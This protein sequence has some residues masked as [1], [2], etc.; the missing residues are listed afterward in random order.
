ML[1]LEAIVRPLD[2]IAVYRRD[3]KELDE[4]EGRLI[5]FGGQ[6]M[7]SLAACMLQKKSVSCGSLQERR[8]SVLRIYPARNG[9]LQRSMVME[10]ATVFLVVH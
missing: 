7:G 4:T 8:W 5:T 2:S 3:S 1:A 10:H 6:V 9:G